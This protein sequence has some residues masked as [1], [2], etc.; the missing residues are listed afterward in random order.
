MHVRITVAVITG[1]MHVSYDLEANMLLQSNRV[2]SS[3]TDGSTLKAQP[4]R[5]R[6]ALTQ[7]VYVLRLRKQRVG[8]GKMGWAVTTAAAAQKPLT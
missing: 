4:T 1:V 7:C 5:G 6:R 2:P 8:V 3:I